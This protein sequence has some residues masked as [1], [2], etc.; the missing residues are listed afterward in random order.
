MKKPK[1]LAR[2]TVYQNPWMNLHVDRVLFPAG[3]IIEEHHILEF[4]KA[5]TTTLMEDSK[6]NILLIRSYR[7]P[8][9]TIEWETPSGGVEVGESPLDTSKREVWEES[10]YESS[11]HELIYTFHPINGT[12]SLE[13]HIVRCKAGEQSGKFDKNEV[14]SI[15]WFSPQEIKKMIQNREVSDGYTL[16][17][18]LLYFSGF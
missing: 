14:H 4:H 1:Q 2:K 6:G 5:G 11:A 13:F 12:S 15:H 9:D 8:T 16:T 17:A 3:R 18:L 10:G 7:Y